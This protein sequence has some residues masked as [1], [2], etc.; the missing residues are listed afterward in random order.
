[1]IIAKPVSSVKVLVDTVSEVLS[2]TSRIVVAG[3]SGNDFEVV[4][5][6]AGL[7][8][9]EAESRGRLDAIG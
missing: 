6:G 5:K 3:L 1:V 8:V 9:S 4:G 2:V 7:H